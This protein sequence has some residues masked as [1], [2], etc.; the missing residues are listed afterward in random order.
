MYGK[1]KKDPYVVLIIC[2]SID[3][4]S[5][6]LSLDKEAHKAQLFGIVVS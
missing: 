5:I 6:K 4:V 1:T 2:Y 3:A